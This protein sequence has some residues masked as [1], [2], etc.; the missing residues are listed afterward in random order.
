MIRKKIIHIRVSPD[1]HEKIL[2]MA[3]QEKMSISEL[4]R[5]KLLGKICV[6]RVFKK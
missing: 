3:K 6:T 1:E 4:F 2:E 5:S